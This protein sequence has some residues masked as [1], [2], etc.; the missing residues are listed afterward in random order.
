MTENFP[1]LCANANENSLTKIVCGLLVTLIGSFLSIDRKKKKFFFHDFRM[2][3]QCFFF[4]SECLFVLMF[5]FS[6]LR[7][8]TFSNFIKFLECEEGNRKG[9]S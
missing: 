4:S 9:F 5:E 1:K 2:S 7:I 8:F 3:F 6:N